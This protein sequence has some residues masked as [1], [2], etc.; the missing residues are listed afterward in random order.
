MEFLLILSAVLSAVTGAFSGPRPI[1]ARLHHAAA[2]TQAIAPAS[3]CAKVAAPTARPAQVLPTFTLLAEL[4]ALP[5]F[6][7]AASAPLYADRLIE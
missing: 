5:A 1:E 3:P 2:A 6:V 7:L 4:R